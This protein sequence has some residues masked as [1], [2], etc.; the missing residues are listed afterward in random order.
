MSEHP[1]QQGDTSTFSSFSPNTT[2]PSL[3]QPEARG[4]LWTC[5]TAKKNEKPPQAQARPPLG[6]QQTP[7]AVPSQQEKRRR[8][9]GER[10]PLN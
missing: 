1:V 3:N 6:A 4:S 2:C 8:P 9:A 10:W 7:D 5:V